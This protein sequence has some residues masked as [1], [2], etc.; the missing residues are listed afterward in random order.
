M[1][2][3]GDEIV[4]EDDKDKKQK[5]LMTSEDANVRKSVKMKVM[6]LNKSE[7]IQKYYDL[8]TRSGGKSSCEKS[9]IRSRTWSYRGN[10]ATTTGCM[11]KFPL[12][13]VPRE[14]PLHAH[15]SGLQGHWRTQSYLL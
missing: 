5:I 4:Q 2:R 12:E 9:S 10:V 11:E 13:S 8:G 14:P 6:D 1:K 7:E 15:R 3:A